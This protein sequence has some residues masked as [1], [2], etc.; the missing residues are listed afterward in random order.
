[1]REWRPV[2]IVLLFEVGVEAITDGETDPH[3]VRYVPIT[4]VGLGLLSIINEISGG[5]VPD[6]SNR[7]VRTVSPLRVTSLS[8]IV[9][10]S[11]S[12]KKRL[13]SCRSLVVLVFNEFQRVLLI[14]GK[15]YDLLFL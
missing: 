11:S 10:I 15:L 7:A 14:L 6:C 8:L 3:R 5:P 12:R 13:V 4:E 2:D 9:R 1:M